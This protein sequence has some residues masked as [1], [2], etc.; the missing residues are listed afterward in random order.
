M[1][2][3]GIRIGGYA[4][5]NPFAWFRAYTLRQPGRVD[6]VLVY[7]GSDVLC[8]GDRLASID[9]SLLAKMLDPERNLDQGRQ[10][11]RHVEPLSP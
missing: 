6:V 10:A 9:N 2:V 7:P 4:L 5:V 8:D 3:N 1:Y 11:D